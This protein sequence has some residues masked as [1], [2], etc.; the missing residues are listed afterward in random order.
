LDLFNDDNELIEQANNL[1]SNELN[2]EESMI[3][4]QSSIKI[5]KIVDKMKPRYKELIEMHY[6]KELGYKEIADLL[7]LPVGTVKAQLFRARESLQ[8]SM[9]N[10]EVMN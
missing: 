8:K 10:I 2:P 6:F 9:R 4:E 1:S 7:H 5:R 3:R